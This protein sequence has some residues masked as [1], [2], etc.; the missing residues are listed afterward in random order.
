MTPFDQSRVVAFGSGVGSPSASHNNVKGGKNRKQ[1]KVESPST[2]QKNRFSYRLTGPFVCDLREGG[3]LPK[4]DCR[5]G[6]YRT[7]RVLQGFPRSGD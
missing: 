6:D 5:D 7:K 4:L 3:S 1:R 2:P